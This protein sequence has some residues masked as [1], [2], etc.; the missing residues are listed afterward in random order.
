M[1]SL[2][3]ENRLNMALSAMEKDSQ[4]GFREA[5]RI[6]KVSRTTLARREKGIAS[7]SDTTPK[8]RRLTNLEEQTLVD[9]IID[10]ISRAFPP[11]MSGV[12]DMANELLRMRGA[13]P[14]G[15]KWSYNFIQR[16]PALKTRYNRK[17]DYQRAKCEDPTLIKEWFNLVRNTKAKWGILDDDQW[18]FDEIGFLMG[19]IH[20]GM[21]VTTSDG[22]SKAKLVQPGDREWATVI[23][24]VSVAGE[25]IPP[26]IILAAKYHLANWY[27]ECGLPAEWVIEITENG[28][29]TNEV[30]YAWIQHFDRSTRSRTKG[31]YRLLILDGHESH[32]SARFEAYCKANDIITL[33]MPA[34]SSHILQP[35]DVGCFGPLKQAYGRQIEA[36]M[37]AHITHITKLEFLCGFREAFRTTITPTNIKAGFLGAGLAPYDPARV[38]SKLDIQLRTPSPPAN[39]P[40][41]TPT[42]ISATPH[43]PYETTSQTELIKSRIAA[44]QNSSPTHILAAVDKLAKGATAVAHQL[45]LL[46]GELATVRKANEALSRRKRAKRTRIRLGGSLTV[47]EANGIL[48]QM[49]VDDQLVNEIRTGGGRTKGASTKPRCCRGCKQP[50]HTI[51]K[52]PEAVEASDSSIRNEIVVD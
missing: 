16:Q 9:Y 22:R 7:P 14:V 18:N 26:F 46:R 44:H 41:T 12:E 4:L 50:G 21:V 51:R 34:H 2:S 35:L 19:M 38:I 31:R 30:G 49:D 37:R 28:W 3:K 27:T 33:C 15:T 45:A 47:Q 13:S 40:P 6:Y 17:Y 42:W 5:A 8:T 32:H 25:A 36:Y 29:T 11:R 52:C 10:L 24:A 20:A 1:E 43:N 48:D 39:P 23:Q